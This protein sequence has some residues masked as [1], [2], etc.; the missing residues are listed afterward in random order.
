MN[1]DFDGSDTEPCLV[2]PLVNK[3]KIKASSYLPK[4][5]THGIKAAVDNR[6]K[7]IQEKSPV[8]THKTPIVKSHPP[9]QHWK[10]RIWW[11]S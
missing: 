5:R 9:H 10:R 4:K 6:P 8:Q 11:S 1:F 2:D 7:K 3:P